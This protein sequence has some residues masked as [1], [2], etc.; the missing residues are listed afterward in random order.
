MIKVFFS[1]APEDLEF[2]EKLGKHLTILKRNGVISTV[3]DSDISQL[4]DED[5]VGNADVILLLVSDNFLAN[6]HCWDV[7]MTKAMERNEQRDAFVVPLILNPCDWEGSP[8]GKLRA[9]P[10]PNGK[11]PI[12]DKFWQSQD[13]A[14]L[15]ATEALKKALASIKK[16]M[17]EGKWRTNRIHPI[18]E[19]SVA[20][21]PP[22]SVGRSILFLAS[23]PINA[24]SI[25]TDKEKQNIEDI[26]K[27]GIKEGR[28]RFVDK[29]AVTVNKLQAEL[30]ENPSEF[31]HFSGHGEG[32]QGL[33]LENEQGLRQLVPTEGLSFLF[34]MIKSKNPGLECVLFNAC[35][36]EVQA[37]AVAQHIKHVIGMN[38][39]MPDAAAIG[40][41]GAFY[42]ALL[43]GSTIVDAFFL[44]VNQLMLS[45]MEAQ[46]I[47]VLYVDG[48]LHELK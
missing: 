48:A 38:A 27:Y 39:A 15:N 9:L 20:S 24:R 40:F 32:E 35:F 26:L 4:W 25:R 22:S 21:T 36:A 37:K 2:K 41:S 13:A 12:T 19:K 5:A 30:L 29:A 28:F 45:G 44:G 31:I 47:P 17:D 16:M 3:T 1:Y 11:Y 18:G 10:E 34:K 33:M 8:F 7:Q 23:N 6:D 43:E 46:T 42:K 14:F